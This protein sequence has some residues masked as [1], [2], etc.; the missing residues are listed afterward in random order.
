M[1]LRERR[2]RLLAVG[3]NAAS[4]MLNVG[5]SDTRTFKVSGREGRADYKLS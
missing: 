1:R 5:E 3:K 4:E 2:W